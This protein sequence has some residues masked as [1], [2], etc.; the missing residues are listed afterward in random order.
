M[1]EPPRAKLLSFALFVDSAGNGLWVPFSLL[2]FAYHHHLSLSSVGAALSGGALL[3][4]VFGG[5]VVGVIVDGIG[6]FRAASLST[7]LR[8]L[9]FPCYL[10][11]DDLFA[12]AAITAVTSFGNR[13]FWAAHAGLVASV[14]RDSAARSRKFATINSVRKTG[15]AAGALAVSLAAAAQ[16]PSNDG[17]Y[18]GIVLFNALS[19]AVAAACLWHLRGMGSLVSEEDQ[20]APSITYRQVLGNHRFVAYTL[21]NLVLAL[22]SVSF[23]TILPVFLVERAELPLWTPGVTYLL[24]CGAVPLF[25]PLATRCSDRMRPLRLLM[26]ACAVFVGYF[27]LLPA[28]PALL[29]VGGHALTYTLVVAFSLAEAL[30]GA[31]MTT[32]V[33]DFAP[34]QARGRYNAFFQLSWGLA[35]AVGPGLLALLFSVSSTVLWLTMAASVFLSGCLLFRLDRVQRT[36]H[37]GESSGSK[38]LLNR[39]ADFARAWHSVLVMRR[40]R[41]CR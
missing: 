24:A 8:A 37:G 28:I 38:E 2:F 13:M 21:A 9:A 23:G 40:R 19:F 3:A 11:T 7:G 31:V 27:L 12:I 41:R 33:L 10:L 22:A 39:T 17:F 26:I 36:P 14:A 4:L 34:P 18:V 20:A 32:V 30:L 25:Q 29:P 5:L 6:A 15:L 35:S 1:V 16:G